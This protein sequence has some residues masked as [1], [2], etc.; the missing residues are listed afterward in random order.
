MRR[1]ILNIILI[2]GIGILGFALYSFMSHV[3]LVATSEKAEGTVVRLQERIDTVN[4]G[5]QFIHTKDVSVW[6]PV[7]SFTTKSGQT[8]TKTSPVASDPPTFKIGE[9]ITVYYIADEAVIGSFSNLWLQSL[10]NFILGALFIAAGL[11]DSIT[12]H[13]QKVK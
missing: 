11:V 6:A 4:I 7:Y 1:I 3:I 2:I 10:A 13:F 5:G 9:K 12:K 8:I